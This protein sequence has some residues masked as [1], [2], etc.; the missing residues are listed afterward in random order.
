MYKSFISCALALIASVSAAA[1]EVRIEGDRLTLQADST[2]LKEV[3]KS[4]AHAGV[5]VRVD[6]RI[7]IRVT[8]TCE[9]RDMQ[10][11]LDALLKDYTYVL[12]WDVVKGPLGDLPRLAEIQIFQPGERE[13]MQ[14]LAPPS[15]NLRVSRGPTGSG[16]AFVEDEIL[17][18]MKPGTTAEQFRLLLAQIGGTVVGSIPELGVYQ[19]RLLPGTNILDLVAQ[20]SNNPQVN[21]VE[22]N[23][24]TDIA[25]PE[26]GTP[27]NADDKPVV[28]PAVPKGAARV[29]ILD[30]GLLPGSGVEDSIVASYDAL[31]PGSTLNDPVGHGTQMAMIASGAVSPAGVDGDGVGVPLV[32]IRTFDDNGNTSN[33]ALMR[34]IDYAIAQGAKVINLSWGSETSSEFV[35]TSVA[36]AQAKGLV[37]VSSAG[38][39]PTGKP[40]Y[41][42]AYPGVVS[43]AA[44]DESGAAWEKSNYGSTI[45]V[46]AAGTATFPVGHNGPPGAYAGTSISSAYVSRELALYFTK[47]PNASPA[48]ARKALTGAV[49]DAGT[50]G[51]DPYYGYGTLDA[52][53]SDKLLGK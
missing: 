9:N 13:A 45:T 6:P 33:Y 29:A 3:L 8:G 2:P 23:Y 48:D 37:M 27:K 43:V 4:F 35:E 17:V 39:A 38:N 53:A 10:E 20:L 26:A 30:S 24:V 50:P 52:S 1:H 5:A 32:A 15:R 44:L 49:T 36:Y 31:V 21:R 47:N 16:P 51:K 25:Q 28:A 19:V 22:P 34:A 7:D 46:A 18:G 12:I 11:A 41:P 42:S 14:P 40:V